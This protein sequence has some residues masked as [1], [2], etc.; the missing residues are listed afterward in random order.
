[1]RLLISQAHNVCKK[2]REKYRSRDFD[3]FSD[4]SS[5]DYE[6][7]ILG[8]PSVCVAVRPYICLAS[9]CVA[10][11]L[12]ICTRINVRLYTSIAAEPLEVFYSCWVPYLKSLQSLVAAR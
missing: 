8:F 10:V 5:R 11:R 1:M 7:E 9:V 3:V 6:N 4:F 2:N 12:C